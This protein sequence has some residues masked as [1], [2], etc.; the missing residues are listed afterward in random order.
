MI[1]ATTL[2]LFVIAWIICL[3][4]LYSAPDMRNFDQPSPALIL[5]EDR[6]SAQ[7]QEVLKSLSHYHSQPRTTDAEEGRRRFV[8]MFTRDVDI[9]I[10]NVDIEGLPAEWVTAADADPDKRLLYLHG[11]VFIVGSPSTHRHITAE[12]SRRTSL[13]VLSIDYRKLPEHKIIH[14]HEDA[15]KAYEWVLTNGPSGPSEAKSLFVAGDSAGGNLALAVLAWARDNSWRRANG[16][17]ALAPL[18][19]ATLSGPTWKTNLN[20]DPFLGPSLGRVLSIPAF[21]RNIVSRFTSD[22][23]GN[24]PHLSPLFGPL[25][26]L[27]PTLIQVSRDEM[28]YS[29]A[30]RYANKANH[31]G[32]ETRLQVWPVMVHVFQGFQLPET[33]HAFGLMAEFVAEKS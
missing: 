28:L 14:C 19:D 31:A 4:F 23:P 5:A 18:T 33:D 10:T 29:D 2:I 26:D 30:L 22:K 8:N 32:S 27:P 25:H 12:L 16:A 21:V 7:H 15:R 9:A 1:F 6:V 24:H 13:S 17:I 3:A 11:G 20:T